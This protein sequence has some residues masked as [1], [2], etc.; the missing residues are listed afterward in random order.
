MYF[1][2][3]NQSETD[4]SLLSV[5]TPAAGRVEIHR[6]VRS[7]DA[8]RMEPIDSLPVPAGS[9]VRLAP[10]GHHAMLLGLRGSLSAGDTVAVTLTFRDA[11]AVQVQ[12]I[13]VSYADL[14]ETLEGGPGPAGDRGAHEGHG[15]R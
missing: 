4:D 10:G 13:V 1:S 6:T 7:G 9:T 12:A 14:E 15:T 11:G 2:V 3:D 8:A 5:A